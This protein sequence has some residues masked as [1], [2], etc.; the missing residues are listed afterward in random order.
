MAYSYA[1]VLT[2]RSPEKTF[3][4]CQEQSNEEARWVC[5]IYTSPVMLVSLWC[6]RTVGIT[7]V[8]GVIYPYRREV[9]SC[10]F[11]QHGQFSGA[12]DSEASDGWASR[13]V[14]MRLD[15]LHL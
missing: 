5:C 7:G 3:N 6:I 4:Q 13:F 8:K 10:S 9:R 2:T 1:L 14:Y 15:L 12:L 11:Q